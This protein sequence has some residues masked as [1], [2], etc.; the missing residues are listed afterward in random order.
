ME[1]D[2][3]PQ[4]GAAARQVEHEGAAEAV[5]DRGDLGSVDARLG[6]EHV[7]AN[8]R[9]SAGSGSSYSMVRRRLISSRLAS[10]SPPPW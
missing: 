6:E 5:A 7:E 2:D 4:F 3:G 10:G 1:A 8:G 9:R